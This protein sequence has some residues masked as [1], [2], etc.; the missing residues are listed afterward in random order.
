MDQAREELE[1]KL[2]AIIYSSI[3]LGIKQSDYL[4][5]KDEK[6]LNLALAMLSTELA[7]EEVTEII[8]LSKVVTNQ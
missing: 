4:L 3:K 8:E 6:V 1:I 7:K 2:G 5:S